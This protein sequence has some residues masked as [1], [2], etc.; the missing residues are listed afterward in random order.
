MSFHLEN[1]SCWH[2]SWLSNACTSRR[3]PS[4]TGRRTQKLAPSPE[5][6]SLR[7][8][9][10]SGLLG[11]LIL[12]PPGCPFPVVSCLVSVYV[13]SENSFLSVRQEPTL[14]PGRGSPFLQH[15]HRVSAFTES[16]I[17]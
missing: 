15:R 1:P 8:A 17:L 14:G 13:S 12:L 11:S 16:L 5:N 4:Q 3:T 2:P 6:P 7:A 9:W 10:Q